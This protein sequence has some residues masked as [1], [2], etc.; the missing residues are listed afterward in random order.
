MRLTSAGETA[1][2]AAQLGRRLVKT[3]VLLRHADIDPPPDEPAP[4]NWPLNA[5]GKVRAQALA[6][7]VGAAGVT[8]IYVSEALRTQ[9]TV[10]PLA[11]K[12]GLAPKQTPPAA[13]L[14]QQILSANVGG[15]VLVAGHSNTVPEMI[16]ALGAP[17]PG[18]PIQGHDDL[19]VVTVVSADTASAIRLKYGPLFP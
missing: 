5:A 15:A 6:H 16:Q 18:S 8:V 12:L 11:A 9:Q 1:S 3:V 17:F 14:A 7:V 13:A 2:G 4:V 19:F 10:A